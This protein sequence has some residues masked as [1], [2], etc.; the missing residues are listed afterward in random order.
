MVIYPSKWQFALIIPKLFTV[1]P[2]SDLEEELQVWRHFRYIKNFGVCLGMGL[3][4]NV[5]IISFTSL[6][7]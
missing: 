4:S 3:G 1:T 6:S 2:V 7:N 5:K